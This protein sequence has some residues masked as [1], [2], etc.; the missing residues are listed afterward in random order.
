M[1]SLTW[2]CSCGKLN[3]GTSTKCERCK[4]A[5][6]LGERKDADVSKVA[7]TPPKR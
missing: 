3:L 1:A 2:F 7:K 5:R 4:L 6:S